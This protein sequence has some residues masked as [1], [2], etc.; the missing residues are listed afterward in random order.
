MTWCKNLT[1]AKIDKL[2][3]I[4]KGAVLDG[5]LH[6]IELHGPT[7]L[8][9]AS[10]AIKMELMTLIRSTSLGTLNRLT[11]SYI[12][13]FAAQENP[14][15]SFLDYVLPFLIYKRYAKYVQVDQRS[16]WSLTRFLIPDPVERQYVSFEG[17]LQALLRESFGRHGIIY[18]LSH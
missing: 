5:I 1:L 18:A 8:S 17:G 4:Q 3:S 13:S 9:E 11:Q 12:A 14:Q 7:L 10:G 6:S 2:N 16:Q 15:W